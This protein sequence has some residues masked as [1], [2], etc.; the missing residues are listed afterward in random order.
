LATY[1]RPAEMQRDRHAFWRRAVDRQAPGTFR[2]FSVAL[3]VALDRDAE[4][5]AVEIELGYRCGVR[6]LGAI[7]QEM[8]DAG[9]HHILLNLVPRAGP[10]SIS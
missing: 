9:V 1:H 8:H 4:A 5:P 3:R 7:L 6:V 10:S 2:S